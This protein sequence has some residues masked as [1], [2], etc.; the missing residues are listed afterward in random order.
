MTETPAEWNVKQVAQLYQVTVRTVYRWIRQGRV[1]A[2]RTPGGQ[3][4]VSV[5]DGVERYR[6][7]AYSD[8]GDRVPG[9]SQIDNS[10]HKCLGN[11]RERGRNA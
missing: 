1:R 2:T 3:I 7:K 4:R 8:M 10:R 9:M 5:A 11:L 6:A